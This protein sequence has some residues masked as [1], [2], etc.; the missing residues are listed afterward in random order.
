MNNPDRTVLDVTGVSIV[1]GERT[2]LADISFHVRSGET[3]AIAGPSG[4]GKTSLLSAILG[5]VPYE[6]TIKVGGTD[7]TPATSS[8]IRRGRLGVVFQ[9]AELLEELS[10]LEN[11]ALG[12]LIVGTS[13]VDADREAAA[14]LDRLDVPNAP[15]SETLSGG[16][17]QRVAL[18]RA[19]IKRPSVILADEPTG[20]LDT[21][22]RDHVADLLF[23]T[24]RQQDCALLLVTHDYAV[25]Q[26]A[27]H[28]LRLGAP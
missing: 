19:L 2:V 16:E 22:T 28:H 3:L 17:R 10:P 26:R 15:T 4:S 1:F 27:Q 13:R 23:D 24:V 20:A 7:V 8:E 11:I 6:G 14:W 18:A 5:Q 21:E 9:H 25:A 12:A